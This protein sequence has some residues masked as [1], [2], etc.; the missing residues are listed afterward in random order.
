MPD[1]LEHHSRRR[2]IEMEVPMSFHSP[3]RSALREAYAGA[4]G[5]PRHAG[6]LAV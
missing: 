1:G 5:Q 6:L 4:I 2:M 3:P